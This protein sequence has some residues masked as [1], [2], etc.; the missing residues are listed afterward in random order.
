MDTIVLA[1]LTY[2]QIDPIA[3]ELGPL[4]VRWYGLAYLAGFVGAGLVLR[5]LARRWDLGLSDDDVLTV[6]LYAVIGLVAGARLGY[7][8]IYGD[9]SYLQ[10]PAH[11][12][13]VWDGGMSFH[14]GLIGLMLG[15]VVAARIL[16]VPWLTLAD[17]G[18]VGAPIGLFLGRLANFVNGELWGR[19]STVPWAM[20]FPGAGTLPRHPS[21]FYEAVLE[22]VVLFAAMML[23]ARKLPPRPRGE[24]LGWF[25]IGYGVF[26]TTAEFFREPDVQMGF[27]F[28]GITTGQLL[29]LPMIAAGI[30]LLIWARRRGLPQGQICSADFQQGDS[31]S[32]QRDESEG[33]SESGGLQ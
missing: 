12:F 15:G 17:I 20:V 3:F 5:W 1:T 6:I 16:K 21:Q 30:V 25:L 23:L 10:N 24:L 33:A 22:G 4:A 31:R 11:I 28:G 7:V 9:A 14:G 32:R 27:L 13:A 18:S 29:S 19:V 8:L 26:R 2:P